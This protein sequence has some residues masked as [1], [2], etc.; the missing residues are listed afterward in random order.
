MNCENCGEK[1]DQVKAIIKGGK[2]YK[3]CDVCLPA[4]LVQGNE[5]AAKYTRDRQREDYRRDITQPNQGRD[6]LKAYGIEAA[7]N[8]GWSEE[9][10]RKL[11]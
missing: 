2:A 1:T 11:S 10:I 5:H 7:R 8:R 9:L 6:Y 3:G 4:Q